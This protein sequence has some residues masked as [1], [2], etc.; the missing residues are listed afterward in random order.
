[1]DNLA[2]FASVCILLGTLFP[3]HGGH[4]KTG[5]SLFVCGATQVEHQGFIYGTLERNGLCWL[6][7]NLGAARVCRHAADRLCYGDLFQWGRSADGHEKRNSG[8][9]AYLSKTDV[10]GHGRFIPTRQP[11]YDWLL[12]Q[13]HLLWLGDGLQE[14]NPCPPGWRL[15]ADAELEAERLS[16]ASN[17]ALG[18]FGSALRW[19]LAGMRE[20]LH[21][22]LKEEDIAAY[23]WSS[24]P[25][26]GLAHCMV[27]GAGD[28]FGFSLY[29]A[30]GLSVRC[31]RDL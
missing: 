4:E 25:D 8:V 27:I 12:H 6:D 17:D 13:N 29:R 7:R 18:A 5:D 24:T 9:H 10:P 23:V 22:Q 31:V 1:M 2:V 15:P 16:W 3:L 19:P 26:R 20:F 30:D 21:G 14:N 11:P 28:A